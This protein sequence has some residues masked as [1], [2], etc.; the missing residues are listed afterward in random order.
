MK[1]N[2]TNLENEDGQTSLEEK[3]NGIIKNMEDYKRE[4]NKQGIELRECREIIVKQGEII[5]KQGE[6]IAKNEAEISNLKISL[7]IIAEIN[8]QKDIYYK[9]NFEYLNKNIRLLLNLYKIFF[10]F[11]YRRIKIKKNKIN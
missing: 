4:L 5:V 7:N 2:Q 1:I 6:I 3:V 8:E 10:Y 9:S 11:K